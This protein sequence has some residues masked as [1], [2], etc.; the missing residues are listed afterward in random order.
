MEAN[1]TCAMCE[2]ARMRED[3]CGIYCVGEFWKRE[4]GS[5]EH[6]L[7]HGSAKKDENDDEA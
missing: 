4:D 3:I 6:F 2:Y 7:E 1:N 5:C